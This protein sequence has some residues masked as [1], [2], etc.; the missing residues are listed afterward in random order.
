MNRSLAAALLALA[1]ALV[2]TGAAAQVAGSTT[3][4]VETTK[5]QVVA[6]GW[7]AR[8][9]VMGKTVYNEAGQAVGR[10]DDL[11]IAP[12]SAVSTVIVGAGGFVGLAR[13]EVAIPAAQLQLRDGLFVLPG[14]SRAAIK[15]LPPFEYA[16][17]EPA[18]ARPRAASEAAPGQERAGL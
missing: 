16:K 3:V 7:S 12:G 2:A 6:T 15:A 13:H 1:P 4:A 10:I 17:P 8:N 14:A 9:Q 11:I 5:L 18:P